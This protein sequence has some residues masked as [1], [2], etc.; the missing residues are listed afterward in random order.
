MVKGDNCAWAPICS[1]RQDAGLSPATLETGEDQFSKA[2]SFVLKI[3]TNLWYTSS[4]K[5]G[6]EKSLTV[7]IYDARC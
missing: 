3:I 2:G 4:G 1:Q 5:F 6:A 7:Y